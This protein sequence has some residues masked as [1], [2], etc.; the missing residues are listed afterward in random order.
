MPDWAGGTRIGQAIKTFNFQWLRRV[1][2]GGP[3]VLVISDGWDRGDPELL[4]REMS[5]LQRS[6]HRLIWLNPL[7]GSPVYEPLTRGI[8]AALPYVDD[9]LPVH[10][11]N[12]LESLA[13]HLNSL[14][15][16]RTLGKPYRTPEPAQPEPEPPQPKRQEIPPA[17]APTF[18]HPAWG[19]RR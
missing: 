10:N 11:L 5:R 7:L 14:G 9:F 18:R 15:R 8:Q 2:T 12:S 16:E 19:R 1:G 6:C 13:D 4:G 3:V 17:L